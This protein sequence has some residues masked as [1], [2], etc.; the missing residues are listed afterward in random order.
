MPSLHSRTHTHVRAVSSFSVPSKGIHRVPL[1]S[2]STRIAIAH[3][4]PQSFQRPSSVKSMQALIS[5]SSHAFA[6][7]CLDA[8]NLSLTTTDTR[9]RTKF[10]SMGLLSR[11]EERKGN[12]AIRSLPILE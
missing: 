7:A 9:F 2:N 8:C 11:V 5:H 10:Q 3:R 6:A 4:V 1:V 12:R